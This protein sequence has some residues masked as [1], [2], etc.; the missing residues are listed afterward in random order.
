MAHPLCQSKPN[1][2]GGYSFVTRASTV[3][4]LL[5]AAIWGTSFIFYRVIAPVL[6]AVWTAETRVLIAGVALLV[7]AAVTRANLEWHRWR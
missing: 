3:Q 5:L 7:F 2:F 4:L 1:R 6:G